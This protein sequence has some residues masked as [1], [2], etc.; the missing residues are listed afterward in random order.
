MGSP[1]DKEWNGC[2]LIINDYDCDVFVTILG[3][4]DVKDSVLVI[5]NIDVPSV[6][7]DTS[8]CLYFYGRFTFERHH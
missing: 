1:I 7:L 4:V 5:T 8:A 3:W 6:Y 2:E